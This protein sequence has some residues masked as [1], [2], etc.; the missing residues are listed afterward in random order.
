MSNVVLVRLT[1]CPSGDVKDECALEIVLEL[2]DALPLAD[3][4]PRTVAVS[5]IYSR[6]DLRV[7]AAHGLKSIGYAALGFPEIVVTADGHV[8]TSAYEGATVDLWTH[9]SPQAEG[10]K[11]VMKE[12]W[13]GIRTTSE[14]LDAAKGRAK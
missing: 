14:K 7:L 2:N 11:L 3:P 8:E 6:G 4:T 13:A 9:D 12:S 1:H 10:R 5:R